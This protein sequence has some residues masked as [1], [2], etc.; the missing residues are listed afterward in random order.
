MK[1]IFNLTLI[2][3]IYFCTDFV[4][5]LGTHIRKF[6]FFFRNGHVLLYSLYSLWDKMLETILGV[7]KF[8]VNIRFIKRTEMFP[9]S[10]NIF[11][12]YLHKSISF[13]K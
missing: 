6:F 1:K 3:V 7:C 5:S 9:L 8:Y 12:L 4:K 11:P 2:E 13:I 10:N